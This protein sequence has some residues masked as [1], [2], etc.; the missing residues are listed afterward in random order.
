[1]EDDRPKEAPWDRRMG[2]QMQFEAN[3]YR[4]VFFRG[5]FAEP[6]FE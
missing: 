5:P 1:M 4:P 3:E 6:E 2:G